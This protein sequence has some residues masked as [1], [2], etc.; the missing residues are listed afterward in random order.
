MSRHGN[1]AG[2]NELFDNCRFSFTKV[3]TTDTSQQEVM[4]TVGMPLFDELLP[5][6]KIIFTMLS[7]SNLM[8]LGKPGLV[9]SYGST[10]TE[11]MYTLVGTTED[12]GIL[13]RSIEVLLD[14]KTRIVHGLSEK[15]TQWLSQ[16]QDT[17]LMKTLEVFED[18]SKDLD[19]NGGGQAVDL[20]IYIEAFEIYNEE[21][22]DLLKDPK[23]ENSTGLEPKQKV[24]LKGKGK[25]LLYKLTSLVTAF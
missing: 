24:L 11:K 6:G 8:S 10:I 23:K 16:G 17:G 21:V 12:P 1:Q 2:K 7:L 13:P 5:G 19:G 22:Y 9:L 20:R 3:F 18:K 15:V 4:K 25:F 14:M